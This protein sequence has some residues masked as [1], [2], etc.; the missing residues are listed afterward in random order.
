MI[1]DSSEYP[2]Q[3]ENIICTM[4]DVR[5]DMYAVLQLARFRWTGH[6]IMMPDERH[7]KELF[8]GE[9]QER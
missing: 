3:K 4:D 1:S 2:H 5:G 6:V 7:S 8:Y 9:L